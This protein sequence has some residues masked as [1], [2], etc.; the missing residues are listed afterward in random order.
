MNF[1]QIHKKLVFGPEL[2][3]TMGQLGGKVY[4]I[5]QSHVEVWIGCLSPEHGNVNALFAGFNIS[6][7]NPQRSSKKKQPAAGNPTIG[8]EHRQLKA[9]QFLTSL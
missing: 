9:P 2:L 5:P 4:G 7:T 8:M 1:I 6:S 3:S